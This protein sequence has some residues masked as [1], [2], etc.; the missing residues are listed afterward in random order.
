MD[1]IFIRELRVETI[2]GVHSW[3]RGSRRYLLVDLELATDI[4]PAAATD[5]LDQT[6]DYQAVAQRISELAAGS[7]FQLVETLAERIADRLLREFPTPWLRLTLRKP[8]VPSNAREAGVI[9][10][11]GCRN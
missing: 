7:D 9:I 2:I 6:L 8:G 4:R 10:E 11:R 5:R 1:I 3:E